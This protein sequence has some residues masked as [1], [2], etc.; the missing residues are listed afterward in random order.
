[1]GTDE[2]GVGVA[3]SS[4]DAFSSPDEHVAASNSP[5]TVHGWKYTAK[6]GENEKKQQNKQR[7]KMRVQKRDRLY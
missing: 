7:L 1:M 3:L 2:D 6:P 4:S 5:G